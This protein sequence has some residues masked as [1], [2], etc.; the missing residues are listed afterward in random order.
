MET[1]ENETV[2]VP[3]KLKKFMYALMKEARRSGFIDFCDEW[4]I[5]YENDYPEISKWFEQFGVT[6]NS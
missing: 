5:D 2:A 4:G 6:L 3:A 1:A